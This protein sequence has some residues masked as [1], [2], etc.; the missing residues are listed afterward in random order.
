MQP[1]IIWKANK[2]SRENEKYVVE[3]QCSGGAGVQFK[4]GLERKQGGGR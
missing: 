3:V 1:S 4:V 2:R